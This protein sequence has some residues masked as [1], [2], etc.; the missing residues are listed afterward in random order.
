MLWKHMAY[1]TNKSDLD[2]TRLDQQFKKNKQ[3]TFTSL[4][5]NNAEKKKKKD[6]YKALRVNTQWQKGKAAAKLFYVKLFTLHANAIN[7]RF[8]SCKKRLPTGNYRPFFC[9]YIYWFK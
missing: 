9:C 7:K 4:S 1:H 2:H 5:R 6:K 3:T 8:Q